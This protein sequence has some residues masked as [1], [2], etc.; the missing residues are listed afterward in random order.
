MGPTAFDYASAGPSSVYVP[1]LFDVHA[2]FRSGPAPAVSN[3]APRAAATRPRPPDPPNK[4]TT[5]NVRGL[6]DRDTPD[7][8]NMPHAERVAIG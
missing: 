6:A 2:P 7:R 5:K 1:L 3:T 8:D 4:P